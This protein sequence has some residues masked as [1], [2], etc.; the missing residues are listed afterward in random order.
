[1]S[2]AYAVNAPIPSKR[3]EWQKIHKEKFNPL[4]YAQFFA[5]TAAPRGAAVDAP[6]VYLKPSATIPS[7]DEAVEDARCRRA[8]TGYGSSLA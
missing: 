4:H 2:P 1:M 7:D 3:H 8:Q 5:A 6:G